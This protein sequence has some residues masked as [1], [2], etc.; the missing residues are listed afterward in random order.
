[1]K[2]LLITGKF[3][4]GKTYFAD[5]IAKDYNGKVFH[6]SS[7]VKKVATE[8]FG[9][10]EKDR[11]LLQQIGVKMRE[12][13]PNVWITFCVNKIKEESNLSFAI[14]DDCRFVNEADEIKKAFG[15]DNVFVI[16]I[17]TDRK[18]RLEIYKKLYGKYPTKEEENDATET[19]V[20]KIVADK[21]I[22]NNYNEN[23]Y[24]TKIKPILNNLN[25]K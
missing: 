5:K 3:A 25:M 17:E 1:M 10:K 6:F 12:I 23:S 8:I 20:D 7:G 4:S 22:F 19:D 14:I 11:T 15:K 21:I 16:K 2:V 9:M 18:Q 13:D 24:E